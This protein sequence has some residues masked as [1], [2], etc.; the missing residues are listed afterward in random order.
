[1]A[2]GYAENSFPRRL[3]INSCLSLTQLTCSPSCSLNKDIVFVPVWRIQNDL[4]RIPLFKLTRIQ[5]DIKLN[6]SKVNLPILF[7]LA[8]IPIMGSLP[9]NSLDLPPSTSPEARGSV[10]IPFLV[11]SHC[12]KN[13]MGPGENRGLPL[14]PCPISILKILSPFFSRTYS[15]KTSL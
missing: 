2:N 10:I 14:S 6:Y 4:I 1:M 3:I 15:L 9:T 5:I 8:N 11:V 12:S 13:Y 7:I